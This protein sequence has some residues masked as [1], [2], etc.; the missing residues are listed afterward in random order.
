MRLRSSGDIHGF[1]NASTMSWQNCSI[2]GHIERGH[3][4]LPNFCPVGKLTGVDNLQHVILATLVFDP[5][6]RHPL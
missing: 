4:T 5:E 6:R 3:V 1:R 2:F